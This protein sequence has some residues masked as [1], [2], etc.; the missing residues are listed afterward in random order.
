MKFDI[1]GTNLSVTSFVTGEDGLTKVGIGVQGED[2]RIA[3]FPED[4]R[5]LGGMLIAIADVTEY[6]TPADYSPAGGAS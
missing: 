5:R 6:A 1:D 2:P 4:A 3:I